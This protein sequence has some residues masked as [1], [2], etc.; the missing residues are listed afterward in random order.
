MIQNTRQEPHGLNPDEDPIADFYT[1]GHWN[2]DAKRGSTK[3]RNAILKM[4]RPRVTMRQKRGY[5]PYGSWDQRKA[6]FEQIRRIQEVVARHFGLP[7]EAMKGWR[8]PRS[9]SEKRQVAMYLARE[10]AESSY[11]DIARCFGGKDHTTV[12]HACKKIRSL[13]DTDMRLRQ[14]WDKLIRILTG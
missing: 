5:R 8:G 4:H 2:A 11:P 3:L 10:L 12:M 14:D 13:C 6:R 1:V 9:V 7:V